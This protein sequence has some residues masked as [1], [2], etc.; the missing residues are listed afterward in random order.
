VGGD[1]IQGLVY[2]VEPT[3]DVTYLTV[4]AGSDKVEVKAAREFRAGIDTAIGIGLDPSRLYFF[5]AAGQR[6]RAAA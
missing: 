6:V 3:G 2:G 5:D 4:L 1:H